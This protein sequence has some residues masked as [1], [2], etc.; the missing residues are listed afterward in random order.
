MGGVP[1]QSG[2]DKRCDESQQRLGKE[3]ARVCRAAQLGA[4]SDAPGWVRVVRMV[5]HLRL[6]T[7]GN[8]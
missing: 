4:R 5:M 8:E 2:G 3:R 6:I 1:D 7:L